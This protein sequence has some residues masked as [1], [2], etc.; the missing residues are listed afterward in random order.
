MWD[1]SRHGTRQLPGIGGL[2][3]ERLAAAGID[4]L[5]KL[6]A[7]DPRRIE[8]VT[9]RHYPFGKPLW[10]AVHDLQAAV[11]VAIRLS[12][13]AINK[14]VSHAHPVASDHHTAPLPLW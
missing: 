1:D 14:H 13:T 5:H 9:Q 4:H 11:S 2:L 3:A 12:H 7:T 8:T 6:Q 10:K